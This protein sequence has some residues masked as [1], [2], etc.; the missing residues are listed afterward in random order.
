MRTY[1]RRVARRMS[2][3]SLKVTS[4]AA[5]FLRA[6]NL[7]DVTSPVIIIVTV[8]IIVAA[9]LFPKIAR[10]NV[11]MMTYSTVGRAFSVGRRGAGTPFSLIRVR[12]SLCQLLKSHEIQACRL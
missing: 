7:R 10:A 1:P 8:A 9:I 5:S 12:P 4:K 3:V 2:V 11:F 6:W